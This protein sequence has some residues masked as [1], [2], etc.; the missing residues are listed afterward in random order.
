MAMLNERE[1]AMVQ[2]ITDSIK[3]STNAI[4]DLT[5][6]MKPDSFHKR[7]VP[8]LKR[9][10]EALNYLREKRELYSTIPQVSKETMLIV[11]DKVIE[12]L[13]ST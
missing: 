7:Q 11:I 1:L 4:K 13:L 8:A 2:N 5:E 6:A 9:Q 10:T 3:N 12:L